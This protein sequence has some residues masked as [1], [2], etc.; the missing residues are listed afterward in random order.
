MAFYFLLVIKLPPAMAVCV[1][2]NTHYLVEQFVTRSRRKVHISAEKQ[3]QQMCSALTRIGIVE[4][5][6]FSKT[7]A[8]RPFN[9]L[10]SRLAAC[11]FH[12]VFVLSSR[13]ENA[14]IPKKPQL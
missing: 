11:M 13:Q 4:K 6:C 3:P 10:V 1:K 2:V 12:F 14:A 8:Q 5:K 7:F 9:K